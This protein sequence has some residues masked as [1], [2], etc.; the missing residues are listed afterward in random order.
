MAGCKRCRKIRI[1][2]PSSHLLSRC[3]R[4]IME[5]IYP[6]SL[7]II[8]HAVGWLSNGEMLGAFSV[9]YAVRLIYLDFVPSQLPSTAS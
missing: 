1:S 9:E 8:W 5:G 6:K 7:A 3:D 4:L 2:Q